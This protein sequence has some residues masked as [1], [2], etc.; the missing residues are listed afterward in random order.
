MPTTG[1]K[2]RGPVLAEADIREAAG[3]GVGNWAPAGAESSRLLAIPTTTLFNRM[4]EILVGSV[5]V[6]DTE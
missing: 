2:L 3:V 6:H 1:R 4:R 5:T